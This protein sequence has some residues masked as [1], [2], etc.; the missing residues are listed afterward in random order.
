MQ[1]KVISGLLYTSIAG[2]VVVG[3]TKEKVT[4][5]NTPRFLVKKMACLKKAFRRGEDKV[6]SVS[7]MMAVEF[8]LMKHTNHKISRGLLYFLF[9]LFLA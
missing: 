9:N 1:R 7:S 2:R 3:I 8:V 4:K 5:R 6:R